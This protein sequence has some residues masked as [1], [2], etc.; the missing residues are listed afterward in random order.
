ML[1][2]SPPLRFRPYSHS[3]YLLHSLVHRLRPALFPRCFL[4]A[5]LPLPVLG[6]SASTSAFVF[7]RPTSWT[8]TSR[9]SFQPLTKDSKTLCHL[10]NVDIPPSLTSEARTCAIFKPFLNFLVL[11]KSGS[12]FFNEPSVNRTRDLKSKVSQKIV[13]SSEPSVNQR[14]D[15]RSLKHF[16]IT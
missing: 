13:L 14:I 15:L 8:I 6:S 3:E 16:R 2:R 9:P 11:C 12:F 10:L 5:C 7:V 4:L 1:P